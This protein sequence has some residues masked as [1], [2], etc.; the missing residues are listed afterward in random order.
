MNSLRNLFDMLL[1]ICHV[2]P[3]CN[4]LHSSYNCPESNWSLLLC[5]TRSL[6]SWRQFLLTK[7]PSIVAFSRPA[8]NS[9]NY[10]SWLQAGFN[11]LKWSRV[12]CINVRT[13]RTYASWGCKIWT[14]Y[15]E[16]TSARISISYQLIDVCLIATQLF[17]LEIRK[18]EI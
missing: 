1:K 16:G 8:A 10:L 15:L 9:R 12:L 4:Q 11:H 13:R 17:C 5:W 6:S 7:W 18:K 14:N 3:S 2:L